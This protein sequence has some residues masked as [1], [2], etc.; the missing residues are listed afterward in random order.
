MRWA[1]SLMKAAL[2]ALVDNFEFSVQD[3]PNKPSSQT[4]MFFFSDNTVQ[5]KFQPLQ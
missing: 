2:C 1:I 4:G 3:T 5:L